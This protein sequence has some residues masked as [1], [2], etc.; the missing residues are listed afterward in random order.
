MPEENISKDLIIID[1]SLQLGTSIETF[2]APLAQYL[3][4]LGLPTENI[5]YPA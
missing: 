4:D 2:N 3:G 1:H 5:L